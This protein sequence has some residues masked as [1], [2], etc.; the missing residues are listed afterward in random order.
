MSRKGKKRD[1]I[2]LDDI[3]RYKQHGFTKAQISKMLHCSVT[4]INTRTR[5][6]NLTWLQEKPGIK[7]KQR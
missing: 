7:K 5:G 2:T 4:T 3:I 1:D 6:S